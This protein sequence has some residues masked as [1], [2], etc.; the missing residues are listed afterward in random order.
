MFE[1]KIFLAGPSRH[2]EQEKAAD[3]GLFRTATGSAASAVP[4]NVYVA[5][6]GLDSFLAWADKLD[7]QSLARIRSVVWCGDGDSL[8]RH[9]KEI[10]GHTAARFEGRW[11]EHFYQTDKDFSDGAAIVSLIEHDVRHL[12]EAVDA[13]WLR[14]HG[15]LAGR[16]DHELANLFEFS[17]ML[18]RLSCLATVE[19]GPARTVTT[20]AL[21]LDIESGRQFSLLPA[22]ANQSC[23]V[24]I[25]G[26][27]YSGEVFLRQPSHGISNSALSGP[28]DIEPISAS[29]PIIV[30]LP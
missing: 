23:A 7:E 22:F 25:S 27:R 17:A 4:A 15:A 11:R 19:F 12:G 28:V 21:R 6:G 10:L 26:A 30:I 29:V 1:A 24:R 20:A 18:A 5:D 2:E 3:W 16:Y 8:G 9:A 14:V 13:C